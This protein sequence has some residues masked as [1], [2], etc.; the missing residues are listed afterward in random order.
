[1]KENK[2]QLN[3]DNVLRIKIETS[4]GKDTGEELVFDLEDIEL[5][6]KYQEIQERAKKSKK[7]L[8]NQL[9]IIKDR[10]DI[11]GKKLLTKNEEDSI[12]ALNEFFNEQVEI[13]NIFLGENGV[14]KLLHGKRLGWTSLKKIDDI[15][16]EQ[17]MPLLDVYMKDMSED[18]I[19]KY[20]TDTQEDVLR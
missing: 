12:K 1:M 4:D 13:Y 5:P 6:L 15:I 7:K 14:Q 9:K 3:E 8:E 17:I 10:P 19:K 2:I 20:K 11:K 18:I 16:S